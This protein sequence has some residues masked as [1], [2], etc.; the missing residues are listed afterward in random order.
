LHPKTWL[1]YSSRWI[2]IQSSQIRSRMIRDAN[3][4]NARAGLKY[5]Q[6]HLRFLDGEYL[7][8]TLWESRNYEVKHNDLRLWYQALNPETLSPGLLS[9]RDQKYTLIT[10]ANV[11]W[12]LCTHWFVFFFWDTK[13]IHRSGCTCE[14]G[15]ICHG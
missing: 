2:N 7:K 6:R 10:L 11:I 14:L 1:R 4:G 9:D 15:K 13:A 5:E 12:K 8:L 3:N